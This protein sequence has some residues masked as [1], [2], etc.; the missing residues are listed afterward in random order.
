MAGIGKAHLN[1]DRGDV[2]VSVE[3]LVVEYPVK[4]RGHLQAVSQVSLDIL[5]G[6]TLGLVGESGCGKTSAGRAILHLPRPTSGK[7]TFDG[8]DLGQLTPQGLRRLRPKMQIIFQDPISS[9][10]EHRR[11]KKIVAEGLSIWGIPRAERQ[12]RVKDLLESVGLDPEQVGDRRPGSFSGGQCQRICIARAIALEPKL[13][14][15]DE[16]VS[17]L[18]VSVQAQILEVLR[19]MKDD[20]GL[21]LLFISHDLA[22][23]KNVCDRVIVMYLGRVCEVARTEEIFAEPAHP[24]TSLLLESIP[25]IDVVGVSEAAERA[26]SEMPSAITPPSGCRYSTRCPFAE[27]ICR[28]EVPEVREVAPGR[29]AACHFPLVGEQRL[30]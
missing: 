28:K 11:V 20:Y 22:V 5:D 26:P 9:L 12:A 15:C 2:L 21:T 27:E 1:R 17:A 18:D 24:Y 30:A 10:N 6:E 14:I 7:V 19:N 3:D 4:G 25:D 16:P 13:V 23:V 29:F 8:I